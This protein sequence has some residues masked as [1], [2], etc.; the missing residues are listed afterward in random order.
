T[1]LRFKLKDESKEQDEVLKSMEGVVT[2]MKSA[3][4]YQVVIGNQVQ[5]VYEQIVPLLH[6]EQSQTVQ[7]AEKEKLLDRF[8]D[9]I[10]GIFLPILGIM[11]A[12]G[13]IKGV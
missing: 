10:S 5:D 4:Q 3:G 12:C 7:S 9:I 6:A 2:V 8:V 13:M 1:R 11:A